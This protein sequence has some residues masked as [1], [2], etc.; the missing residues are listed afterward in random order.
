M[1]IEKI[2]WIYIKLIILFVG[3]TSIFK[4]PITYLA[5]FKN[6]MFNLMIVIILFYFTNDLKLTSLY[7]LI[8]FLLVLNLNRNN[9]ENFE[10]ALGDLRRNFNE[11]TDLSPQQAIRKRQQ[12]IDNINSLTKELESKKKLLVI[13]EKFDDFTDKMA[14]QEVKNLQYQKKKLENLTGYLKKN[15]EQVV[16]LATESEKNANKNAENAAERVRVLK[17]SIEDIES[18]L[19][20]STDLKKS[21]EDI[22]TKDLEEDEQKIKKELTFIDIQD[23]YNTH[24]SNSKIDKIAYTSIEIISNKITGQMLQNKIM[25]NQI[26][27]NIKNINKTEKKNEFLDYLYKLE[28][29]EVS[30]TQSLSIYS[31]NLIN[32]ISYFKNKSYFNLVKSRIYKILSYQFNN[33]NNKDKKKKL[34]DTF[35][36][37]AFDT[38]NKIQALQDQN[39]LHKR[40]LK[41]L[42]E[43]T[44]LYKFVKEAGKTSNKD[45][46]EMLGEIT[47]DIDKQDKIIRKKIKESTKRKN[48]LIKEVKSDKQKVLINVIGLKNLYAEPT[49]EFLVFEELSEEDISSNNELEEEEENIIP[50]LK[51]N[52]DDFYQDEGSFDIVKQEN[53]YPR[54][55][56]KVCSPPAFY[57]SPKYKSNITDDVQHEFYDYPKK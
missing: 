37:N 44:T 5:L 16:T 27:K 52:V 46:I 36:N 43:V 48:V 39:E 21:Y 33:S 7:Y 20:K 49:Y 56:R 53:I 38:L 34:S 13:A 29:E 23:L 6:Y 55:K 11:N 4:I 32:M 42:E 57:S 26:R 24:L 17:V 41:T 35:K 12:E 40:Y 1:I 50:I 2:S 47:D 15:Q 28:R 14:D 51:D 30:K 3:I 31:K 8:Y 9:K 22:E 10:A 25:L 54:I 19:E 18:N 45:I